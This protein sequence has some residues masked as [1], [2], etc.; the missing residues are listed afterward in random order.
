MASTKALRSDDTP[1]SSASEAEG[2][3]NAKTVDRK[4]LAPAGTIA[5]IRNLY[6]TRKLQNVLPWTS[7]YPKD[8]EEP[9]ENA[10]SAQYALLLRHKKSYDMKTKLKLESIVIQSPLLKKILGEVLSNYPGVT[11]TL[12]HLEFSAPFKPLVHRWERLA[13]VKLNESDP[14]TSEHLTLLWDV[15]E[16]ELRDTLREKKDLIHNGVTTFD[17]IWAI[18]EPGILVFHQSEGHDRIYKLSSGDYAHTNRGTFFRL[19]CE[20]VDFDGES[21]GTDCDVLSIPAFSGTRGITD[22]PVFPLDRYSDPKALKTRLLKRG[23]LFHQ[24]KGYHFKQ[25][26]G[27]AIEHTCLGP[28]RRSVESRVIVDTQAHNRFNPNRKVT[29][30]EELSL[31]VTK[32]TTN[33][34]FNDDYDDVYYSDSEEYLDDEEEAEANRFAT[35]G[36]LTEEQLLTTV[37][38]LRGYSLKDKKWLDFFID[39]VQ[40]VVWNEG[41]FDALVAPLDHKELI[42]AFAESQTKNK[43]IFD[44][45]I[46]GKGKGIIMLLSGPPGVGKTLT[47]ESVAET[48]KVPL[49]MMS[50]GDLGTTAAS[51]ESNLQTVLEMNTKWNAVLLLDEAD[52]MLEARSTHDLHRNQLV[53]VFLRLLEYFEGLMFLTTNRVDNIDAA[54]DSRIHLTIEYDELNRASRKQ[55]WDSFIKKCSNAV[56]FSDMELDQLAEHQYNGRQIKNISKTA[57]LLAARKEESLAFKHLDVVLKLKIRNAKKRKPQVAPGQSSLIL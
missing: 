14:K 39:L 31:G 5:K 56:K 24:L 9:L 41:A 18:F 26:R 55:I 34:T 28:V 20:Y 38:H 12:Q 21:F 32:S 22:L 45:V 49:Y 2:E 16:E 37:P 30:Q 50:S 4:D 27:V 35:Q 42:L 40:E 54:F 52:V 10:E 46:Q 7:E 51:V 19:N 25:Y 13:E 1:S 47:A 44:D 53:S 8:L 43:E 6:E 33:Q 48:M 29:L 11:T 3:S 57:Q 17:L 36:A 15:L 23:K